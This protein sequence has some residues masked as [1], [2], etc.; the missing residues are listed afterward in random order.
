MAA[1]G[2]PPNRTARDDLTPDGAADGG[3]LA[4]EEVAARVPGRAG[5]PAISWRRNL[6]AIWAAQIL[7][8]VGFS[9]RVPFLPFYLADL[10]V[11]GDEALALWTGMV[12]AG[13]AGVM[14]VAA[15]LWGILAD[16]H[17]RRPMLIRAAFAGAATVGLMAL[18]TQPWHLLAL[19]LVEGAFT[20]T[21]TASTVLV[22]STTPKARLGYALGMVQTAVFAGASLGP[23]F[24]GVLADRIGPRPTFL[25][26]SACL[27]VSGLLVVV[28]VRERF[29]PAPRAARPAAGPPP[30]RLRA[31]GGFL[32]AGPMLVLVGLLFGVRMASS[33]VQ[34]IVPLYVL[35]LAPDIGDASSL[36]GLTLGALGLTSA[37]SAVFL[38]RLGDRRDHR[39]VLLV[40]TAV[41]GALY[42]PMALAREPWHLVG[43]MA[44]FGVAAGGIVPSANALVAE[45]TPVE[46]RGTVFGVTAAASSAGGFVGPLLGAGVAAALGFRAPF[47]LTGAILLALAALAGRQ[48]A[49]RSR[50]PR[51]GTPEGTD[52]ER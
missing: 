36:A 7:A 8:I 15:P 5:A 25:V 42:L 3:A 50:R 11:R 47:V 51:A 14:M 30:A 52:G 29:V 44:L 17:G 37:V 41:G 18:A 10:G 27:A 16:R 23:L 4:V 43:L 19:R 31:S 12:N 6:W 22:A 32:L 39:H 33:A 34:P 13:G 45:A 20:G 2:A 49:L 24:G 35:Q 46:R 48:L 1:T 26:A 21:V 38:G 40:A 28:F 9:L